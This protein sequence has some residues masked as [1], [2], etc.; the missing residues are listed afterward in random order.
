MITI[1]L[2]CLVIALVSGAFGF[3][4]LSGAALGAAKF[5]IL[6]KVVCFLFLLAFIGFGVMH[7]RGTR[8]T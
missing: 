8:T 1:A 4:G 6:L 2:I 7:L 3:T 5:L